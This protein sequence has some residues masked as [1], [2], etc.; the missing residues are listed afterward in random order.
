MRT[1][2][3]SLAFAIVAA[4]AIV[5]G[6]VA[7]RS[8]TP[9]SI[10]LDVSFDNGTEIITDQTNFCD[11]TAESAAWVSG[12]GRN[13]G[14]TLVFH[15]SRVFTCDDG[16]TLTIELDAAITRPHGGTAGGWTVIDGT[17]TMRAPGAAGSSSASSTRVARRRVRRCDRP[18]TDGHRPDIR[19]GR[20]PRPGGWANVRRSSPAATA[21]DGSIAASRAARTIASSD[22]RAAGTSRPASDDALAMPT[23]SGPRPFAEAA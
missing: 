13:D 19:L 18:L 10:T 11:G 3:A 12:G 15:V 9:V 23:R 22:A 4:L 2:T 1:R 6:P 5:A 8:S 14:G 20:A 7:A 16:S 17:G 21:S